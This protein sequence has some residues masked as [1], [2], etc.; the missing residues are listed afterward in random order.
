ML[1]QRYNTLYKQGRIHT[2]FSPRLP[3]YACGLWLDLLE[4]VISQSKRNRFLDVGAGNGRLTRILAEFFTQGV[5]VEVATDAPRWNQLQQECPHVSLREGLLQDILPALQKEE[6]FD[7]VLLSEVFEHIPLPDV[8]SF[9]QALS[10]LI[11]DDGVI[12]LTTPNFLVQGPAEKSSRWHEIEPYG[13]YKHYTLQEVTSALSAHGFE[14]VEHWFECHRFKSK[15]Y[16][17][18]YYPLASLDAKLLQSKKL[19]RALRVLYKWATMPFVP[20][21]NSFF[22]SLAWALNRYERTH[23]NEANA[24]TMILKIRKIPSA[25]I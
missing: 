21:L 8:D 9:L 15:G 6:K 2:G 7:F 10:T 3:D 25:R 20:V 13:H 4:K 12:F 24:E 18:F 19:P 11:T 16:S 23:N 22:G 17:R 5:A 14:V 1:S